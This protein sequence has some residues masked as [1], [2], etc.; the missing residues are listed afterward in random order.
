VSDGIA[1]LLTTVFVNNFVTIQFLG[2]CPLLG[3]SQKFDSA[4]GVA[5]GTSFVLTLASGLSYI[6]ETYILSPLDLQYLRLIA[7]IIITVAL[8]RFSEII[9]RAT[10]PRLHAVLGVLGISVP[11]IT[12]NCAVLGV[13]LINIRE[14]HSFL[15]SVFFGFGAAIGFALVLILFAAIQE[16]QR[17]SAVPKVFR[18]A[19]INMITAGLLSLAF[20]GFT[21]MG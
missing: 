9:I 1:I 16:Q 18:G 7:F 15:Q 20:M 21:G 8:V 11:L 12:T 4:I 2:L 6:V 19:A 10:R 14:T 5:V 3:A 17:A 13:V